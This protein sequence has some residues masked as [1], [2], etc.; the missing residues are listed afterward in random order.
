MNE[1]ELAEWLEIGRRPDGDP[2]GDDP[3]RGAALGP[4]GGVRDLLGDE[5]SW[6]EPPPGGAEDLL[7][8]IRAERPAGP[9]TSPGEAAGAE[10]PAAGARRPV[11]DPGAAGD[12]VATVAGLAGWRRGARPERLRAGRRR[13]VVVAGGLAAG[14]L[15]LA[16]IAGALLSEDSGTGDEVAGGERFTIAATE[17]APGAEAVALV[18]DL[19]AGVAIRL[20]V[21]GLAG[22]PEGAYYQ[23]WING[24][25][26]AV[27]VGT[28]HMRGGDGWVDLW[29]G[30]D[31][32]SYPELTVTLEREGDG[33]GSSG[34]VVLTGPVADEP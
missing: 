30:V 26:G 13:L 32:A 22:A 10:R 2:G 4:A 20:H 28:F 5:A 18:Q 12:D 21:T 34:D 27:T 8:A 17:R 16:G 9:A 6:A 19:P 29:S 1:D 24:P 23:G 3:R 31:P 11:A 33:P 25:D 14:L 15:V 7:A